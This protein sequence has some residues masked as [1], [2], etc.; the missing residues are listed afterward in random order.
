M[1]SW[2]VL[3]WSTVEAHIDAKTQ[4]VAPSRVGSLWSTDRGVASGQSARGPGK[5]RLTRQDA[6]E[7][8]RLTRDTAQPHGDGRTA[9][10]CKA[11]SRRGAV[12]Q[13]G[14]DV[15]GLIVA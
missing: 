2:I 13:T 6:S 15:G 4:R 1:G 10:D 3:G 8:T 14:C 5:H 7:P 11:T 9:R 12:F